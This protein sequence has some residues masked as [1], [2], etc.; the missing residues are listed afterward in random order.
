MTD[1][2]PASRS[3][4]VR[5][6]RQLCIAEC[7]EVLVRRRSPKPRKADAERGVAARRL[8]RTCLAVVLAAGEGTRMK[9]AR[10]KVLHEIAGRSMLGH[11]LAAIARG[12]GD[13]RGGGG[14]S[15]SRRR[16]RRRGAALRRRCR[17][18]RAGRAPRH[19][20]RGAGGARR[21]RA[22]RRRRGDRLRR[23]AA[24][25]AGDLRAAAGAARR[26]GDRRGARLRGRGPDRLRP[27]LHATIDGLAAIREHKDASRGGASHHALQRRADGDPRRAR[28]RAPRRGRQP[29]CAGRVL[30]DRSSSRSPAPRARRSAVVVAP[31]AEVQGINDRAQLAEVEKRRPGAPAA[32]GD[33]RR[34]DAH[35]ARD[36]VLQPRHRDRAGRRR[37]AACGLRAG[38]QD[39]RAAP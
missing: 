34:R 15:G 25:R 23:H 7:G 30:P 17:D 24:R 2:I 21:A 18:L 11:V 29:Q 5:P 36:G 10:P 26:R 33:E 9:S 19:G 37:R 4:R 13:P 38:G 39:R 14:R 6:L 31:E 12:R 28:A 3:R 22:R 27:S 35:R 20:A 8:A 16:R 32:C 1:Q